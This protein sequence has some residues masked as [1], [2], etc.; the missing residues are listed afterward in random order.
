MKSIHATD[1]TETLD[2]MQSHTAEMAEWL[3]VTAALVQLNLAHPPQGREGI[4]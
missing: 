4:F 3:G 2:S 1:R